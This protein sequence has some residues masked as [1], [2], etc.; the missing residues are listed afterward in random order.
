M[1]KPKSQTAAAAVV[2]MNRDMNEN[3][4]ARLDKVHEGTSNIFTD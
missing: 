3:I 2:Y 1:R 4:V